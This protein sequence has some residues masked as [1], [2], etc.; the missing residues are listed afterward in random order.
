MLRSFRSPLLCALIATSLAPVVAAADPATAWPRWTEKVRGISDIIEDGTPLGEEKRQRMKAQCKGVTGI[1]I[2]SGFAMP[3]FAQQLMPLCGFID[4]MVG[5]D[6][7][8]SRRKW[9]G[10]CGTVHHVSANMLKVKPIEGFPQVEVEARRLAA[11]V[12]R[13]YDQQCKHG[14]KSDD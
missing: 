9:H 12:A 13:F 4:E 5:P 2:G 10:D 3:T 7:T 1:V 14:L 6:L 8:V 11:H